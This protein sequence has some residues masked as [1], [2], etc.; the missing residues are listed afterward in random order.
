MEHDVLSPAVE[1]DATGLYAALASIADAVYGV[2]TAG[3]VTF[4]NRAFEA[5]TGYTLADLRGIPSTRLYVPEAEP[6]FAARR[7]QAYGGAPV[8]PYVETVMRLKDGRQL[9]VE[10][11]VSSL[12]IEGQMAGR[13][14]VLRDL[15]ER[16]QIEASLR[17]SE[18]RFRVM[19]DNLPLIVWLHDAE[20][21]QAFVN[22]TF[23]EYFGVSREEMREG[24]WRMLTHP[25]DERAYVEA[26]LAC[27]RERTPFHAEVRVQRADG[28]WRWIESWARPQFGPAGEFLGHVGTSADVTERKAAE[29]ML[30][31]AHATLEQRVAERTAALEKQTQR[32]RHE[33]GERQRMQEA[34]FQQEKLAAMG[35]L[36][37]SVAHELNNPLSVAA[38]Q[39]DNLQDEAGAG[40]WAPDLDLLG[41]AI[42]RCQSVVQGFL[43]LVR[44]QA[45]TRQAVALRSVLD[46]VLVLLGH[47][48]EADGVTIENRLAED[49]PPLWADANQLHHVL[50]NLITNAHH[51]LRQS[52]APR[53]LR[54]TAM[55]TADRRQVILEVA[56]SGPGMPEDVQRR[57]FDPFFTTKSPGEGSGLGLPLCRSMIENHGGTIEISS[58]PGQG[59]TVSLTLPAAASEAPAPQD[60]SG[61]AAP[62]QPVSASI[63]LIDDEP[64]VLRALRRLLE[65]RG[66]EVTT[67]ASGRE[68]LLALEAKSYEV[69]LCDIR[70]PDLDGPGFYREL[71]RR[72]PHLLARLVFLTGDVLSPEAQAFFAQVDNVRLEKPFKAQAVRQVIEQ[73]LAP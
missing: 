39:L 71:E 31:D 27:V 67:A 65:R 34:L 30:R 17:E 63:L 23:C 12:I 37:A 22:Q 11:S 72:Y 53:R 66:H 18:E 13:V 32:L 42:E 40:A 70:M 36:L 28:Q 64:G 19:A 26:F 33:M 62:A 73:I 4:V 9:P 41:Q 51:V 46:D 54:L 7:R 43:A 49:L 6:L 2:D 10:L 58:Q 1:R 61:P 15:T 56:D 24:R 25:D 59:T 50:A 14:A 47:A 57:V 16:K 35:T 68:G 29:A 8:P 20:G 44:Q 45:P 48:L 38:L 69:I 60:A 3:H 21:R 52:D 5:M 55:A